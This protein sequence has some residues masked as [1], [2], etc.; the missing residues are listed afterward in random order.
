MKYIACFGDSLVQGFPFGNKY[1]WV[2][3]AG[4][5]S[6]IGV[7]NYGLCGDCCDDIFERMGY[8]LLPEYVEHVLFLGGANDIIQMRPQSVILDDMQKMADWCAGKGYKLCLVLPLISGE[9]QLNIHLTEL[10]ARMLDRFENDANI[11]LLNL[12]PAIG[13]DLGVLRKAYLDG[14]HPTVATYEAM[15]KYAAPLLKTWLEK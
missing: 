9:P 2:Q 13:T 7:L 4:A 10:K 3:H 11:Y 12:Q 5:A 8:T 15:G 14:V 1:S 6:K